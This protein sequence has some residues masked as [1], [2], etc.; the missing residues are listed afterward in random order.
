VDLSQIKDHAPEEEKWTLDE[1]FAEWGDSHTP[2]NWT[3]VPGGDPAGINFSMKGGKKVAEVKSAKGSAT[4]LFSRYNATR[5]FSIM[6]RARFTGGD[7]VTLFAYVPG[8]EAYYVRLTAGQVEVSGRTL[9]LKTGEW[10]NY[11]LTSDDGR[12]AKLIIDGETVS[13]RIEPVKS[14][15]FITRGIYCLYSSK[16]ESSQAEMEY[17]RVR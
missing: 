17:I 16:E 1:Q 6:T 15:L 2:V 10:H 11:T 14:I 4:G 3:H 8:S 9:P 7:A 12:Y 13:S 5:A